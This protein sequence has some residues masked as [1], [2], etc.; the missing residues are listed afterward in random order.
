MK[1]W[2]DIIGEQAYLKIKNKI[3]I[4]TIN[5]NTSLTGGQ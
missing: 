2:K 1:L 5:N 3:D 4:T